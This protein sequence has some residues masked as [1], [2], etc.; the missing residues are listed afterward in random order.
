MNEM[1]FFNISYATKTLEFVLAELLYNVGILPMPYCIIVETNA[2]DAD[3]AVD[4]VKVADAVA[5]YC[6]LSVTLTLL[7]P[8]SVT[9]PKEPV[10]FSTILIILSKLPVTAFAKED[11]IAIEEEY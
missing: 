1:L 5:I 11:E 6:T 7:Y 10:P 2:N 9:V 8:L 4:C 3:I